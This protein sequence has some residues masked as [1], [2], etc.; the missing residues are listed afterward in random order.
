MKYLVTVRYK[1]PSGRGMVARRTVEADSDKEA[2]TLAFAEVD[3]H[4]KDRADGDPAFAKWFAS[5]TRCAETKCTNF[6]ILG[7]G[8]CDERLG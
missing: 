2:E 5:V 6:T 8:N 1:F 3:Q 7:K 4:F